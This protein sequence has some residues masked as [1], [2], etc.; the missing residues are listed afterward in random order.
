MTYCCNFFPQNVK[1]SEVSD[2]KLPVTCDICFK[3]F[4]RGINLQLH[5]EKVA[6]VCF[7][8]FFYITVL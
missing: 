5:K 1:G 2:E 6:I 4:K 8:G 7:Y 3:T